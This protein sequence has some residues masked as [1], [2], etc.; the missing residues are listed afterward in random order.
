MPQKTHHVGRSATDNKSHLPIEGATVTVVGNKANPEQTDGEG[1]FILHFYA[2]TH[3]GDVVRV[4]VEKIGYKVYEVNKA[5]RSTIALQ[6]PLEPVAQQSKGR[7]SSPASASRLR[8]SPIENLARLGWG[9]KENDKGITFEITAAPLPDMKESAAYL[10]GL[11]KPFQIHLQQVPSIAGLELLSNKNCVE[12]EIGASNIESI[13]ELRNLTGLRSL[14]IGQTPFNDVRHELDIKGVA[15]LVNLENLNLSM[16]RVSDLE[17]IRGLT[18]L[19]S[20]NIG[21][22]LVRDVSPVRR[23]RELKS[24]DVRDSLVTDLCVGRERC[25]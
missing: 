10:Q 12:V 20:L 17:P 14:G 15:S 19:R 8:G 4:H 24:L 1:G 23:M 2:G 7:S 11:Q 25:P 21:G 6:I 18:K 16:A 13:S 3:E 5:I 9:I 22:T